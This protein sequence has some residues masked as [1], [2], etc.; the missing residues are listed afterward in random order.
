M[1][2]MET[3]KDRIDLSKKPGSLPY[4]WKRI[5]RNSG[6]MIGLALLCAIIV[7]C[8]LSPVIMKYDYAAVDM[9]NRFATPS[10]EHWFGCD[11]LGR[12][13]M[14]RIFYGA[15][16][17]LSI[18][19]GAVLI[20]SISG[21]FIGAIAGY[22]GGTL[23]AVLMR[24]LDV[25]QSFPGLVSAIAVATV[26][27]TGLGN[28][29][30]AIGIS[31]MP[32]FAR[33]MR[34]NILQI[35]GSE[36]IEA[37]TIMRCSTGRIIMRHLVPN[38]ISPIIVQ[39]SMS[40]AQA[41]LTASTLSFLGLGVK[42]PTPERGSVFFRGKPA[43]GAPGEGLRVAAVGAGT[44]V[45]ELTVWENL[46]VLRPRSAPL[47]V[48]NARRMRRR[49]A[50]LL[51]EYGLAAD[52]DAAFR[53]LPPIRRF[54]LELLRARLS[55]AEIAFALSPLPAGTAAELD[56]LRTLLHRLAGEGLSVVL[57]DHRGGLLNALAD[58]VAFFSGGAVIKVSPAGAEAESVLAALSAG[59]P[60]RADP[61]VADAAPCAGALPLRAGEVTVLRAA[62]PDEV[63]HFAAAAERAGLL[64]MRPGFA[65]TVIRALS[66]ADNLG[67]GWMQRLG[68]L[69]V[70]R[71]ETERVLLRAFAVWYGDGFPLDAATCRALTWH[72]CTALALYRLVL[73]RPA[74]VA[75]AGVLRELDAPSRTLVLRAADTL[76]AG[77]AAVCFLELGEPDEDEKEKGE[78]GL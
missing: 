73:R 10:G 27:G 6:A 25:L 65:Q 53:A 37:A 2:A 43:S 66:P 50:L 19:V 18:G 7:L 58:R 31:F 4:I 8:L 16:Y 45:G 30:L 44:T 5:S 26:L 71:R 52:P 29:I 69:G 1:T 67:L 13:I 48:L 70:R 63:Q 57:A 14:S 64:C 41:A 42:E 3:K 11:E 35:R 34:A 20:A 40:I 51:Y 75:F 15:R 36:Y 39:I 61:P 60:R 38:A 74:A 9:H 28:S 77:G 56:A 78:T 21:I 33:L 22:F 62:S 72:E 47:R 23:D 12:D 68:A 46:L 55:G 49:C 32:P 17:T 76:A 59:E 24:V 54:S